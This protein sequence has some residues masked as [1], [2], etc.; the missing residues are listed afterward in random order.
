MVGNE[1]SYLL[2][3]AQ[4]QKLHARSG[5]ECFDFLQDVWAS[6]AGLCTQPLA[7]PAGKQS[8]NNQLLAGPQHQKALQPPQAAATECKSPCLLC[9][10]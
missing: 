6:D 8:T 10:F 5:F 4:E 1:Q 9:L 2:T 3:D 7:I